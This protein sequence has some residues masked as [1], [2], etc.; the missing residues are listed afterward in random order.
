[1]VGSLAFAKTATGSA[2]AGVAA[3]MKGDTA[4]AATRFE[5]AIGIM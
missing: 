4:S 2:P 1:M 3:W 5:K